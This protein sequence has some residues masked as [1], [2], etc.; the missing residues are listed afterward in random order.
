[1]PKANSGE[2]CLIRSRSW[3]A[4]EAAFSVAQSGFRAGFASRGC[5]NGHLAW[6]EAA[7]GRPCAKPLPLVQSQWIALN[8]SPESKELESNDLDRSRSLPAALKPGPCDSAVVAS[9]RTC[10]RA[11]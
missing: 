8:Q 4:A 5:M 9:A 7:G 3:Y 11:L 6:L 2:D 1:V 10:I